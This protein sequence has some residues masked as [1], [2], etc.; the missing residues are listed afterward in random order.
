MW[1]FFIRECIG[2]SV[3]AVLT[4][5]VFA[6][7]EILRRTGVLSPEQSRKMLHIGGCVTALLFPVLFHSHW[8]VLVICGGFFLLILWLGIDEAPKIAIVFLTSF[9][10]IYMN[11]LTAVRG[12][13]PRLHE[14]ALVLRF[15]VMERF[16]LLTLPAALP[17]I[18]TG[19]RLGFGYSWRAL[20]GAELIAASSG[21]G[22]LISES[23]E[24]ARTET[25]FVGIL[26][27]AV[28][29][30]LMDALLVRLFSRLSPR[31]AMG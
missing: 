9:F 3:L 26:T 7:G 14:V 11:T 16:R 30:V 22:F 31:G 12:V 18:F 23:A 1:T 5:A 19:L 21:L 15:T 25:V 29:G 28:L 17:G 10:P 20:V 2:A 24:F 6:L 4:G 13:D 27:I 8:S